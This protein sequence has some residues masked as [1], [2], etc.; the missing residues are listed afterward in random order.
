MALQGYFLGRGWGVRVPD[1]PI[2]CGLLEKAS[3]GWRLKVQGLGVK[4]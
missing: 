2:F 1:S 4:V 3:D